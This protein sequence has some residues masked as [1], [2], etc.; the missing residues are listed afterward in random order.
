MHR[1]RITARVLATMAVAA[2]SGCVAVDAGPAPVPAA[3]GPSRPA[4]QDVAPQIV[5][6]PAR[7]ALEA[8][9]PP[10]AAESAPR[11]PSRAVPDRAPASAPPAAPR[12]APPAAR[13]PRLPSPDD[14]RDRL[15]R[16]RPP[17]VP[18]LPVTGT[19]PDVCALGR[20]HG[21]WDPGSREAR[22]CKEAYG[23]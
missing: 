20:N 1:T 10:P 13:P 23:H 14:P 18:S 4:E 6:G 7:E 9:L 11:T 16:V 22:L 5:E 8:A 17:A 3:P 19:V 21:G 2:V 15:P 12:S